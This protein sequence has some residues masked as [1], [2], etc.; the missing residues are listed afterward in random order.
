MNL[1]TKLR[2]LDEVELLELLKLTSDDIV[3]AFLDRIEENEEELYL[4]TEEITL[5]GYQEEQD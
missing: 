4:K 5:H 3:D 2:N 1:L